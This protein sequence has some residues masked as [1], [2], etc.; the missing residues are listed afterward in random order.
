[1]LKMKGCIIAGP[2]KM[3]VSSDCPLPET[4]VDTGALIKP[5]I[6]SPCTSDAHLCETGAATMPYLVGKAV[7]HEMCGE[8]IQ[9]GSKV[10]D[11][12]V[13]DRVIVDATMPI[14]R[15]LNTQLGL[16]DTD[17]VYGGYDD[18]ER[19]GSFVE[20]YYIRD[21]DMNLARIPDGV[22][23]EQAVM[24]PDMMSTA[25]TGVQNL[26]I[27]FGE[28][29]L[30][31]GIGP[32]GLMGVRGSV[33]SEAGRV[34]AV[35]S[36]KVCVDL[37]KEYGA[38]QVF[39]YH[40]PDYLKRILEANVGKPV[41]KVLL[42]GGGEGEIDKGLSVLR[43]GGT[44]VNLDAFFSGKPIVI[45]PASFGF[46]FGEKTIKG[47]GCKGGRVWLERLVTLIQ[48]GRVNPEKLVTHR[49]HG[50]VDAIPQGMDLFLNR[51]RT[52]I[53]PV[54]YND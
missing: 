16:P 9:I 52:M 39:D 4:I 45:Q 34:F 37:A 38:T 31:I 7:G 29:V 19:G 41:D 35:G 22:T 51:D 40:D 21:A 5:L 30:V 43:A 2:G 12:K 24:V 14:W 13:G 26:D 42:A 23:L 27:R 44:L 46:G 32:V 50:G 8:I 20:K 28:T 10:K 36:R 18:P 25:F 17:S 6:W 11:F 48:T 53:K 54:I 1:M 33:L 3:A 49:F 15:S 47:V